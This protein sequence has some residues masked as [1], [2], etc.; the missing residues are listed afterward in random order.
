MSDI[1]VLSAF[2]AS[3]RVQLTLSFTDSLERVA[4]VE[5]QRSDV[6]DF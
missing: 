3:T 2:N 6:W 5:T 1:W 4:A